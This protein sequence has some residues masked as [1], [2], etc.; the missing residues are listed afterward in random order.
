MWQGWII[1]GNRR[2]SIMSKKYPTLLVYVL[3]D[4]VTEE[5]VLAL[6]STKHLAGPLEWSSYVRSRT[7]WRFKTDFNWTDAEIQKRCQFKTVAQAKKYILAYEMLDRYFKLHP[8]DMDITHWSK[9]H[10]ACVPSLK[11]HLE[12]EPPAHHGYKSNFE[13]FCHLIKDEKIKD[14]RE[15]DGCVAP[16]LRKMQEDGDQEGLKI[17]E[18]EGAQKAWEHLREANQGTTLL[19]RV[20]ATLKELTKITDCTEQCKIRAKEEGE[21]MLEKSLIGILQVEIGKYLKKTA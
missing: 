18:E 4:S 3:P 12:D 21:Y 15:S 17:L 1:E 11:R 6:I 5:Q 7:A 10:H 20:K 14:C 8:D 2:F 9:F 16:L 19:R 13:W